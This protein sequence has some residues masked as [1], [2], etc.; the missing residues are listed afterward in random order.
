M[1]I[2]YVKKN[3]VIIDKSIYTLTDLI[4]VINTNDYCHDTEY[5][6]DLESLHKVKTELVALND[7][8]GM[9]TIK[10]SVLEQMLFFIQKIRYRY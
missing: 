5:N 1:K 4:D 8:I 10:Q 2:N 3:K 7:M 9:E 6:I